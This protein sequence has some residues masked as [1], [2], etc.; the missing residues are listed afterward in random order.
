MSATKQDV[1]APDRPHECENHLAR[2]WEKSLGYPVGREDDYFQSGGD[3]LRGAQLIS[4]IQ[5]G[6]GIELSL[7][8]LFESRTIAEQTQLVIARLSAPEPGA[9][10]P[11]TEFRYFGP[12]NMRLFSALHRSASRRLSGVVL[13][14]PMGQEYMRIHRTYVELARSLATSGQYVLRFDYF[15]CGDSAGDTAAGSLARWRDDIRQATRELR[16]STGVQDVYLVGARVGANLVLDVASA[17]EDVAG[18]VLWEPIVNGIDYITT[19]RRSHRDLL[20]SNTR[21]QGY[22]RHR[23]KNCFTELVGFPVSKELHDEVAA[24]DLLA[25][26]KP[27]AV[28][29]TLV[30]ANTDKPALKSY[31]TART[32]G[33]SR[34]DYIAVSESDGIWLKEDRQNKGVIPVHAVQTIVS[35]ISERSHE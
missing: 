31:A 19:L 27:K 3:S 22:E 17:G 33:R 9:E 21:L 11:S 29:D 8:D 15:G 7:L 12:S 13:C 26:S 5:E 32:N 23:L 18:L 30:L 20:T 4:W 25:L 35:W 34:L 6:F 10:K 16:R 14:Y 2:L 24:I 28:P 1:I